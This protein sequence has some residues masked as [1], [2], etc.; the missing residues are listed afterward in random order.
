VVVSRILVAR[1]GVRAVAVIVLP[2]AHCDDVVDVFV[3]RPTPTS[4]GFF[5]RHFTTPISIN[6]FD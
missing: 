5:S 3:S 6:G 2:F 4:S 1:S